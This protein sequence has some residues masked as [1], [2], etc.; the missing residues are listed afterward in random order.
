[1]NDPV[2]DCF[3]FTKIEHDGIVARESNKANLAKSPSYR[4]IFTLLAIA[5]TPVD[6]RDRIF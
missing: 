4:P 5:L 1:M 6:G 2:A 3:W